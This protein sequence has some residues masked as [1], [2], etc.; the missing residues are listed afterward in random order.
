MAIKILVP[1]TTLVTDNEQTAVVPRTVGTTGTSREYPE[2]ARFA[3]G[4]FL[5]DVSAASGTNPTLDVV[6]QGF[7]PLSAKWHTVVTFA[8]QTGA[9]GAG[10]VIAAQSTTLDFQTYRAQWTV[11]GTNTPSFTFTLACIAHTEEPIL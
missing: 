4:T 7:N 9:T 3:R 11:G 2:L 5:F 6:I 8:Q 10:S 1:M